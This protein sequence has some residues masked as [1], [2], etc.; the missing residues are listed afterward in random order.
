MG[1]TVAA[2]ALLA[3]PILGAVG[4][5]AIGPVAGSAATAW[6]ASIGAVQGVSLFAW[7]QSAAMGG[8][9]MGSIQAAGVAGSAGAVMGA[10]TYRGCE[11]DISW[12]N[13]FDLHPHP[14]AEKDGA[15]G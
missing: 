10:L 4:F 5:S 9:A 7:C 1:V 14:I 11:V 13:V 2:T 12:R 6:Q 8:A 15:N 3:N